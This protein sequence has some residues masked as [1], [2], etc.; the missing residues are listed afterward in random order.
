MHSIKLVLFFVYLLL[1]M[2][3][4]KGEVENPTSYINFPY[5]SEFQSSVPQSHYDVFVSFRGLDIREGFLSHLVDA[6]SRKKIVIFVDNKLKKGD[7]IAQSLLEAIETSL[8]SLVIFS[9]NYATSSWCLDELVKIVECREKDGQ[10]LLPVF[11]KVDPT[12]VRHQKGTYANAFAEHEEKLKYNFTRLQQWRSA[13][14]KSAD[15][16]G[17]HSS[18]FLSDAELVEEVVKSVLKRLDHV[19]IVNSKGLV[20][21]EKQVSHVESLLQVESQDVRAI[22]I[23]GM[24][25]IGKTIIAEDIYKRLC[26]EYEGCYFKA[27]IREE[28]GGLGHGN[29]YLKKDLFSTLLGEQDLKIDTPHGLPYFVARRLRR[30]KVL[31]VLD[32]VNDPQQLETL[33]G[34]LDWFG[35]GSRIIVTTK[36]KQVVA[37]MVVDNEKYEVIAL[38]FDDSFRPISISQ[39]LNITQHM[40]MAHEGSNISNSISLNTLKWLMNICLN[41]TQHMERAHEGSNISNSI[42]FMID[43]IYRIALTIF[44]GLVIYNVLY[45]S[46]DVFMALVNL[47]VFCF[48]IYVP[49]QV[50]LWM[51]SFFN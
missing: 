17:F 12:I 35:T 43:V 34:T 28:W 32:D 20:G 22:G 40:E 37:K 33:V 3:K 5:S 4:L 24:S 8:I 1:F 38:D 21:I 45:F 39:C 23:W 11:Y 41:I 51:L 25:V 47:T 49:I 29:M 16:S 36:D 42:S 44:I 15:I 30:M 10:I 48:C 7:E 31:V 50:L 46:I 6:F 18:Q 9:Q 13:L 27:N 14:K 26:S 19:R 2:S